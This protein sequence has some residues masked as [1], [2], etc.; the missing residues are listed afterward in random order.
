MDDK[1]LIKVAFGVQSPWFVKDINLDTSTMDIYLDFIK[2]SRIPC[3]VCNEL[4]E[5]HDTKD[6][7][8][9]HLDFFHYES[10]LHARVPRTKCKEHGVKLIDL[11]WS[12]Q[13][14]GFTLFFEALIVAMSEVMPVSAVDMVSLNEESVWRILAHYVNKSLENAQRI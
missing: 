8:W 4:S 5:I 6:R 9:R 10:Y 7:I 1:G 13:N 3:P 12:R 2:G 14:T 11:P